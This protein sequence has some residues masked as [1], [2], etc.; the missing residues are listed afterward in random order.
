MRTQHQTIATLAWLLAIHAITAQM[1]VLAQQPERSRPRVLP[2]PGIAPSL[3]PMPYESQLVRTV[4]ARFASSD[5]D[6][7]MDFIR[8][9]LPSRFRDF[10]AMSVSDR[11][12]ASGYLTELVREALQLLDMKSHDPER[13]EL[14]IKQINLERRAHELANTARQ[15]RSAVRKKSLEQLNGLLGESFEVKQQLMKRDVEEMSRDLAELRAL[16]GKR[17]EH[18]AAI[19]A[20]RREQ[21]TGKDAHLKW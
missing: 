1:P 20:R 8:A 9:N 10:R 7:V 5:S 17:K 4:L 6:K 13:F 2:Q 18:R 16:L 19:I 3:P 15:A 21:L 11:D 14:V 12:K